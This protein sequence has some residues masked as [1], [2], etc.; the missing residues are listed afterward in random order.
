M[1][2]FTALYNIKA[3]SS[4][5]NAMGLCDKDLNDT[6]DLN[7]GLNLLSSILSDAAKAIDENLQKSLH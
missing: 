4:I 2:Y 6:K 5:L 7:L 3:V 1:D